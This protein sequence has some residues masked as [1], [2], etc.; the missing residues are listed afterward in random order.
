MGFLNSTV[1]TINFPR[2]RFFFS[3]KVKT[4]QELSICICVPQTLARYAVL[5]SLS[6]GSN[7]PGE[8]S[9]AIRTKWRDPFLCTRI[10]C[11]SAW[12]RVSRKS[13]LSLKKCHRRDRRL[14][15]QR[16]ENSTACYALSGEIWAETLTFVLRGV[17]F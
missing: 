2:L 7:G 14:A 3:N 10:H 4:S 15:P 17:G 13:T 8:G 6:V 16:A 9:C 1:F 5:I 11:G 12:G